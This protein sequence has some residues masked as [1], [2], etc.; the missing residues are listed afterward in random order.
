MV[1]NWKFLKVL[2]HHCM[3]GV[4]YVPARKWL[5]SEF[6]SEPV[7]RSSVSCCYME[8]NSQPESTTG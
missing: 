4:Q 6:T 1:A 2:V 3:P 8:G 5:G 7:D